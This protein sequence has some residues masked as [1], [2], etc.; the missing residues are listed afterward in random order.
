MVHPATSV[1]SLFSFLHEWGNSKTSDTLLSHIFGAVG[2]SGEAWQYK[3]SFNKMTEEC[4]DIS[5]QSWMHVPKCGPWFIGL[6]APVWKLLHRYTNR[7]K[8]FVYTDLVSVFRF[9][10]EGRRTDFRGCLHI[11][12]RV[13]EEGRGGAEWKPST[14]NG[15]RNQ[16]RRNNLLPGVRC[17]WH[18]M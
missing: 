3:L 6:P 14:T 1:S 8:S 16:M 2:R 18:N 4:L 12:L 5:S 9:D 13:L 17:S 7:S 10:R 15:S 11:L